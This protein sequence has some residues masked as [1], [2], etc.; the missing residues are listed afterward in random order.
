MRVAASYRGIERNSKKKAKYKTLRVVRRERW[1]AL[2]L[3]VAAR[4]PLLAA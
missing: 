2:N 1:H 4:K 3:G